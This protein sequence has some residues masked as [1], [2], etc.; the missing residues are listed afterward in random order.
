MLQAALQVACSTLPGRSTFLEK[1]TC[2]Y[3]PGY[4]NTNGL[5]QYTMCFLHR[6]GWSH[7]ATPGDS[8]AAEC[9]T[10]VEA[11]FVVYSSFDREI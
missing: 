2:S 3:D 10:V 6:D 11:T 4:A 8:R 1:F 7:G 5:P 9:G